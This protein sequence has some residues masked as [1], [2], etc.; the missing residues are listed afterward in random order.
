MQPFYLYL[1]YLKPIIL[2]IIW[3]HLFHLAR[4]GLAC[5]D[6]PH[7][8]PEARHRGQFS[9]PKRNELCNNN[10]DMLLLLWP[11]FLSHYTIN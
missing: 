5:T 9:T 7:L 1:D 10:V 3:I 8:N 4:S 2:D 11:V 6:H